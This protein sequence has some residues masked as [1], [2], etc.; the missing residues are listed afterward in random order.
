VLILKTNAVFTGVPFDTQYYEI[1]LFTPSIL[2]L[3][4]NCYGVNDSELEGNFDHKYG[5]IKFKVNENTLI[6]TV[7]SSPK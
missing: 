1:S 6:Y 4:F 3:L 7:V 2:M 5:L